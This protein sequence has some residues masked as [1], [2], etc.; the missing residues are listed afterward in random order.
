MM[1]LATW[2]ALDKEDDSQLE[3]LR[4]QARDSRRAADVLG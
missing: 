4:E 2:A 3:S 1:I